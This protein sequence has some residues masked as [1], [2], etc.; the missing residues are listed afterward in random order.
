MGTASNLPRRKGAAWNPPRERGMRTTRSWH[1]PPRVILEV[2]FLT[3]LLALCTA[4]LMNVGSATTS[5]A[6]HLVKAGGRRSWPSRSPRRGWWRARR[7]WGADQRQP[8]RTPC[9]GRRKRGVPVVGGRKGKEEEAICL[10][11][12]R[13]CF[14]SSRRDAEAKCLSSLRWMLERVCLL[15]NTVQ[16]AFLLLHYV[17]GL[18]LKILPPL[19]SKQKNKK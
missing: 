6:A 1:S 13:C 19:P 3:P 4:H 2:T 11:G 12:E 15:K 10:G 18:S 5:C 8:A 7:R 17:I 16:D 9:R 14:F